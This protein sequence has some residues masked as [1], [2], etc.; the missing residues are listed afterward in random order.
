MRPHGTP[1]ESGGDAGLVVSSARTTGAEWACVC[2]RAGG[3]WEL[4]HGFRRAAR[5]KDENACKSDRSH[6]QKSVAVDSGPVGWRERALLTYRQVVEEG[7]AAG[8]RVGWR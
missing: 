1:V 6:L 5:V 3:D 8:R 2:A 4:G 7:D